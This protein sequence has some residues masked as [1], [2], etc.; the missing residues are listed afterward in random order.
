MHAMNVSNF[1]GVLLLRPALRYKYSMQIN[2]PVIEHR[3]FSHSYPV[4]HDSQEEVPVLY[5]VSVA[6][7]VLK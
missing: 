3:L 1:S 5:G 4:G 2:L 6:S 7:L